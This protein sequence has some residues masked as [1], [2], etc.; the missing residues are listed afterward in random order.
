VQHLGDNARTQAL[1]EEALAL[2]DQAGEHQ[3]RAWI[4]LSYGWL[5]RGTHNYARARSL[6][7]E[8]LGILSDAG[9]LHGTGVAY[10][11]LGHVARAAGDE[12]RAADAYQEALVLARAAGDKGS[13]ASI[14]HNQ[15]F[16]VLHRGDSAG[17][18]ALL[19]ESLTLGHEI[20]QWDQIAWNLA[21]LGGVA[22]AQGHAVR[23]A[24]LLGAANAWFERIK[25]VLQA[26]ERAEHD[27]YVAAARA[28][29]GEEAFA[30]AWAEG[31]G[32]SLEQAHAYA[33][34]EE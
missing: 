33:L 6:V 28:Q 29:L 31:Y 1:Y 34:G 16:L 2:S 3:E 27:G 10:W 14:L 9:N 23:A 5:V 30:A 7:E 18:E 12:E 32:M 4:L 17:A 21:A 20:G 15:A 19:A 26:P 11:V 25:R 22:A 13:I 8:G 24:R